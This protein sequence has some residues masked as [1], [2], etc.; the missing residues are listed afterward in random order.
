MSGFDW[1]PRDWVGLVVLSVVIVALMFG[2]AFL[3]DRFVIS[4]MTVVCE[5]VP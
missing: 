3:A 4:R 2:A 1:R 5:G